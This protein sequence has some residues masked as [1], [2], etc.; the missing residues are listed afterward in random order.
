[1]GPLTSPRCDGNNRPSPNRCC[2]RRARSAC[3]SS[4]RDDHGRDPRRCRCRHCP[5]AESHVC[6]RPPP[7][8]NFNLPPLHYNAIMYSYAVIATNAVGTVVNNARSVVL[9]RASKDI[10]SPVYMSYSRIQLEA[11]GAG[12]NGGAKGALHRVLEGQGWVCFKRLGLNN[13]LSRILVKKS[14]V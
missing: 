10:C 13:K 11:S 9:T 2:W 6:P 3:V 1:V 8:P 14:S 5:S 12:I 4:R 7:W